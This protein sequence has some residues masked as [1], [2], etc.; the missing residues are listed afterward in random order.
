MV[1]VSEP[2]GTVCEYDGRH[3]MMCG[4]D[5][6]DERK[7]MFS[8]ANHQ[9]EPFCYSGTSGRHCIDGGPSPAPRG[10][11]VYVDTMGGSF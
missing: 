7:T 9:D 10:Q 3:S 2:D 8:Q 6:E 1:P 5:W 4:P 11:S